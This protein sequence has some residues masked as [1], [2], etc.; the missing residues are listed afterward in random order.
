MSPELVI[1]PVEP[2]PPKRVRRQHPKDEEV[3][4]VKLYRFKE[5]SK[6]TGQRDHYIAIPESTL[7]ANGWIVGDRFVWVGDRLRKVEVHVE[8][9]KSMKGDS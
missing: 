6:F 4:V 8:F 2:P 7:R 3:E 1:D 5:P 9:A